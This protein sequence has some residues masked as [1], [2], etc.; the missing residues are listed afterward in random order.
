MSTDTRKDL[1][2]HKTEVATPD[3]VK[4]AY[5]WE[6]EKQRDSTMVKG[7]F[8]CHE[9]RGGCVKFAFKAYKGDPVQT[10]EFHDGKQY[11]IPLAVAKHLNN[12]CNYPVYSEIL[13]PD[14]LRTSEVTK[15]VQRF[16]FVQTFNDEGIF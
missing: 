14:G 10:Y 8:Q 5:R 3:A 12:N 15:R 16:N 2:R 4:P 13:G 9:P 1:T 7:T 6:R 11:T